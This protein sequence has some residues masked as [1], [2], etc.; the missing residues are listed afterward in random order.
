MRTALTLKSLATAYLEARLQPRLAALAL[1]ARAARVGAG[2]RLGA[3]VLL[4]EP[5]RVR[6]VVRPQAGVQVAR[7]H[8]APPPR[9]QAG[10]V[11]P[12]GLVPV[13][14]ALAAGGPVRGGHAGRV[15]AE[16]GEGGEGRHD[17]AALAVVREQ[18]LEQAQAV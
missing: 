2:G 9:A 11:L 17:H 5:A 13:A 7:P 3:P 6:H 8:H 4:P 12:H 1:P 14:L 15:G 18:A 10:D 16:Q